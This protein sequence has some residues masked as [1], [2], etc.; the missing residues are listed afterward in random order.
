MEKQ[1]LLFWCTVSGVLS[2]IATLGLT[3]PAVSRAGQS[4]SHV[5]QAEQSVAQ[6]AP[7]EEYRYL[8]GEHNGKLA[9]F[10]PGQAEPDTVFDV[11]LTQLPKLDAQEIRQGIQIQD[12]AQLMR[13]IEDYVT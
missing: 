6:P 2:C 1:K 13:R 4:S 9:V 5:S 10:L 7:Q 12:Y 11:Y 8:I 3:L